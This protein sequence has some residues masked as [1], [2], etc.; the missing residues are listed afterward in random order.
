MKFFPVIACLFAFTTFAGAKTKVTIKGA[1]TKSESELLFLIGGRLTHVENDRAS[2]SRADDAA[3]L[4]TQ[5]MRKDGYADVRVT[6][7]VVN[8]NEIL[9]TVDE[10]G[11]RSVHR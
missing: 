3:F 5:V 10:G 6:P 9:L 8:A 2:P 7:R 11:H 1:E 4:L